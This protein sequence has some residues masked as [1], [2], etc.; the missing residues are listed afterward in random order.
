MKDLSW[1]ESYSSVNMS[2]LNTIFW[3]LLEFAEINYGKKIPIIKFGKFWKITISDPSCSRSCNFLMRRDL[4]FIFGYVV[5]FDM[6]FIYKKL[7][8]LNF[9][10]SVL[11]SRQNE[12]WTIF[13][14]LIFTQKNDFEM[15]Y[16]ANATR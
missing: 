15:L 6:N 14:L 16:L 13:E 10:E 12:F 5:R 4:S 9:K 3:N 11:I 1:L 7:L 2:I 8:V